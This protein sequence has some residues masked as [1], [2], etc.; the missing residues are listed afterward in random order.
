MVTMV[1]V[2]TA[3]SLIAAGSAVTASSS[4]AVGLMEIA[5]LSTVAHII[6]FSNMNACVPSIVAMGRKGEG[7]S[8]FVN[9]VMR[10]V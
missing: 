10:V 7:T 8:S 2:V 1:S 9:M 3:S 6:Y 4:T 5:H